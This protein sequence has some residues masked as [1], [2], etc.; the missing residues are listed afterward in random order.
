[1]E[2]E[3]STSDTEREKRDRPA[4][5]ALS[6]VTVEQALEAIL[7]EFRPLEPVEV[8]LP[9]ALGLV[10]AEDVSADIDIPPFD[11]SSM[12]GYAVRAQDTAS[13][14]DDAPAR[15]RVVGYLPAGG[16]PGPDDRVEQGTA[17]RIM[18]GAPIPPGADAVVRFEDTS[19]GRALDNPTLQP[20]DSR[21]LPS[22]T[23]EEVAIFRGVRSGTS[24][25]PAGG[26]I[27]RGEIVLRAGTTIR[28]AEIG[29]L[30]SV[31]KA[32]VRVHRRPLAVVLATG[33]EL[34]G[35][36]QTPGPGQ[37]RNTNS[38]AVT[39]LL[40][41][42]GAEA[43]DLGVARDNRE[44]LIAKLREA[45]ALEPD[46][47]VTSAGVSV[48]DYDIVK[49]VLMSMGTINM[50][51]VRVKPGK[52][53]AFGR[54]GERGVPFLGLPGN[55]VSSM[56]TMELFGRPAV[57]KMMGMKRLLRPTVNVRLTEAVESAPGRQNYIRAVVWQKGGE[58][59]ARSTGAQGSEI[60]TSMARAN[61]FLV[62]DERTARLEAG[63]TARAMLLDWPA[64]AP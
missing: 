47:L 57:L 1:M 11:N 7:Q 6:G 19:E 9:D 48:G 62:V 58:Y 49:E 43:H 32:L 52:P 36:D 64:E 51:R 8:P 45:L 46:L 33:D 50:W 14:S 40:R 10:L 25:R 13:A 23:G 41:S 61:A 16:A 4:G 15:L 26:D 24:V 29:V 22:R 21:A 59:L 2:P 17:F 39:A 42:W 35:V 12:D 20:G 34:V 30:A 28:P 18:T 56:V 55:P 37:I 3:F 5:A 31:G 54:L 44:H 27:R 63:D 60:L 38:Y 53:L